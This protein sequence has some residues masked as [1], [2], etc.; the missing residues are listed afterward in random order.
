MCITFSFL[1]VC[2]HIYCLK[3]ANQVFVGRACTNNASFM[4]STL[5]RTRFHFLFGLLS[6]FKQF[7]C[8]LKNVNLELFLSMVRQSA[9]RAPNNTVM[10][11]RIMRT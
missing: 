8:G 3:N 10:H 4:S 7:P 5:V 6:I 11:S 1:V 2:V 9:E